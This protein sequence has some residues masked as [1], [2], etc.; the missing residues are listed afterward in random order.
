MDHLNRFIQKQEGTGEGFF[1][2]SHLL[3]SYFSPI[4]N[5]IYDIACVCLQSGDRI[6]KHYVIVCLT[7]T[8]Q[9]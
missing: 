9:L 7:P 1:V 4:F 3:S 2:I 5:R 6:Q 8:E